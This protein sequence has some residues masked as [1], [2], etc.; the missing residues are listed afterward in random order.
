MAKIHVV[1]AIR[2]ATANSFHR[3]TPGPASRGTSVTTSGSS[4]ALVRPTARPISSSDP[5]AADSSTATTWPGSAQPVKVENRASETPSSLARTRE[6]K[7]TKL[8]ISTTTGA[9][10]ASR[11]PSAKGRPAGASADGCPP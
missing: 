8:A 1:T 3:A 10:S 6:P 5:P 4:R 11:M 7:P 2:W 9:P